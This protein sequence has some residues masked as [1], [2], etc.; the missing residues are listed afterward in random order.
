MSSNESS[1]VLLFCEGRKDV[2]LFEAI[3]AV[4]SDGDTSPW[5]TTGCRLDDPE[6]NF[7][8]V[9]KGAV[10]PKRNRLSGSLKGVDSKSAN[11]TL[12]QVSNTL[13]L[14][15]ER[16]KF[17]VVLRDSDGDTER[18]NSWSTAKNAL[19]GEFVSRVAIGIP[20]VMGECWHI[21][22]YECPESGPTSLGDLR[23]RFKRNPIKDS[24]KLPPRDKDGKGPK[25]VLR[26]LVEKGHLD[27][28]EMISSRSRHQLRECG[29]KNGL[30]AFLDELTQVVTNCA[31]V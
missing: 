10:V 3:S 29:I 17:A 5:V 24:H 13:R 1:A 19:P 16:L 21:C 25:P 2:L 31:T 23:R 18:A 11:A 30:A 22:A 26:Y 7:E 4:V 20:H 27:Q 28:V 6:S 12:L 14:H 8:R 15:G 9:Q